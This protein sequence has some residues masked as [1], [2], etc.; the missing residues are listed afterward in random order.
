MK[1]HSTHLASRHADV[2]PHLRPWLFDSRSLTRRLARYCD[3]GPTI[4]LL[5]QRWCVPTF[6]ERALLE[7][8]LRERALVRE[9]ILSCHGL[10][11]VFARSVFPCSSIRHARWRI[12]H[13]GSRALG[14]V[15]FSTPGMRRVSAR[16]SPAAPGDLLYRR[17]A[18]AMH[19]VPLPAWQRHSIFAR[20]G[21]ALLVSE[22]FL[23]P[24]FQAT[25]SS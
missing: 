16:V 9:V 11:S 12:G 21:R 25:C 19:P 6:E 13:L 8:A 3:G 23:E 14:E 10:P 7:L 24:A 22:L 1:A 4:R 5:G 18:M 20:H 15:L 2:P 17:A